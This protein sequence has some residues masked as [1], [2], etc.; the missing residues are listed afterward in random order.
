MFLCAENRGREGRAAVVGEFVKMEG[1]Y[2][3]IRSG[4]ELF[5]VLPKRLDG[6]KTRLLLV[7][8]D[9]KGGVLHSESVQEIEDGFDL[10][11]FQR[12]VRVS[13]KYPEIF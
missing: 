8:G 7:V 5:K 2:V 12:L 4:T 10:N 6:F 3:L 9:L 13:M 1:E 11:V